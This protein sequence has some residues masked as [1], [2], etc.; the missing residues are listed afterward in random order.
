M[1]SSRILALCAFLGIPMVTHS[2]TEET[3]V[4]ATTE[5]EAASESTHKTEDMLAPSTTFMS[6]LGLSQTPSA[7]GWNSGR[8]TASF[9]GTW[10]EQMR[11]F[12]GVPPKDANIF[13]GIASAAYG[14]NT[15]VNVF[16]DLSFYG[17]TDYSTDSGSGFGNVGAGLQATIPSFQT[18]PVWVA[19]E[20]Y[21][22][23]G[24]AENRMNF[25]RADG[26]DYHELR[27]DVDFLFRLMQTISIGRHDLGFKIH[28]NEGTVMTTQ[29]GQNPLLL[30]G[31][32]AQIN[33][34]MAV[35]GLEFHSRTYWDDMD[36]SS[37]PLWLTPSL[38][39]R[40][41]WCFNV[42]L[43]GDIS[44]S[45]DRDDSAKTRALEPY[46]LF[47]GLTF[48]Y[49]TQIARKRAAMKKAKRDSLEKVAMQ[50]KVD[51]LAQKS[52]QDS[53]ALED[54]KSR[55]TAAENRLLSTGTLLLDTVFF[56]FNK[57]TLLLNSRPYLTTIAQ[58]L[59]K[60]PK[61]HL[62]VDG[63]TDSVGVDA[64]NLK[65]SQE[66][67]ASVAAFLIQIS[68]QLKDQLTWRGFGETQPVA[69]NGTDYGRAQNRRT[70]LRVI[71]RE[72]LREY[73]R[74][75]ERQALPE[76]TE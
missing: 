51:S 47:A 2:Q 46:R 59:T 28:A 4:S 65:L 40:T 6:T 30:L 56:E 63:H 33:L 57:S 58:M 72:A 74:T 5:S 12:P 64:Y 42:N 61:L 48:S 76:E 66:R 31:V 10:Y 21:V 25:N 32:G 8:L 27:D 69:D 23:Y 13:T 29:E 9:N 38:Q 50:R 36:W 15:F 62:E 44:V 20:A 37:D 53:L 45:S 52:M 7:E 1:K 35:A 16:G 60:Y 39:I 14:L 71:N 19:G 55:R 67:A 34:L 43:G 54:E 70:E 17:S 73:N 11:S 41:P 22:S 26:Y 49:D 68:P 18:S 75:Q 24:F 3:V